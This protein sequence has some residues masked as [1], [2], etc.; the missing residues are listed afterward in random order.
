MQASYAAVPF[1]CRFLDSLLFVWEFL[2]ILA[3]SMSHAILLLLESHRGLI[4]YLTNAPN[5]IVCSLYLLRFK[6][7]IC[8]K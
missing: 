1:R 3:R 5:W 4:H 7:F 2:P 6:N 8:K